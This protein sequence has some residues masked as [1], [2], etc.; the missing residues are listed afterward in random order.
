[1]LGKSAFQRHHEQLRPRTGHSIDH[2]EFSLSLIFEC[3][4]LLVWPGVIFF[5]YEQV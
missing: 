2:E 5:G 4:V 1:M 3:I